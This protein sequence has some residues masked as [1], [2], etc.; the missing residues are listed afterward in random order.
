MA[1]GDKKKKMMNLRAFFDIFMSRNV[2]VRKSEEVK[3]SSN[4]EKDQYS[5]S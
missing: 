3:K 1:D 5:S 2:Y 4:Q